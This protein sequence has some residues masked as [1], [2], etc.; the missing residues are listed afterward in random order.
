MR[1]GLTR[2]Q[3]EVEAETLATTGLK[4][5]DDHVEIKKD[6]GFERQDNAAYRRYKSGG[7]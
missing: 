5:H 4:R 1:R 7:S 3:A 2:R 6:T